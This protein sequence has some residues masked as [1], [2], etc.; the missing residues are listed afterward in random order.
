MSEPREVPPPKALWCGCRWTPLGHLLH[1][2]QLFELEGKVFMRKYCHATRR[3]KD[4]PY[5]DVTE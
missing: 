5:R 4:F 2:E 1:T 3:F